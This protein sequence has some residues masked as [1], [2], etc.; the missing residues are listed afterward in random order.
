MRACRNCLLPEAVPGADLDAGGL[1]RPCREYKPT[2]GDAAERLRQAE[3]EAATRRATLLT[4]VET[5]VAALRCR[6]QRELEETRTALQH[7]LYGAAQRELF[8]LA[9]RV[10]ADLGDI[11][12]DAVL[13]RALW[14]RIEALPPAERAPLLARLHEP[15]TPLTIRTAQ[16]L[17]DDARHELLARLAPET[18]GSTEP[19]DE[20]L[21][22]RV[23][24]TVEPALVAGIELIVDGHLVSWTVADYLGDLE[25]GIQRQIEQARHVAG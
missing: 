24:F 23:T 9:R 1:C 21:P 7:T 19:T 16:P 5:E 2:G 8:T 17:G 18:T 13:A 6:R 15:T 10:L 4:E 14:R 12:L 25:T 20:V 22:C 11:G 3:A